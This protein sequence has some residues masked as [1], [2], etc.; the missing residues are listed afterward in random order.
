MDQQWCL[1]EKTI[2]FL[3][4]NPLFLFLL[5]VKLRT[6]PLDIGPEQ[7]VH[8]LEEMLNAEDERLFFLHGLTDCESSRCA[9]RFQKL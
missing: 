8:L 7:A 5:Y 9:F 4:L 1:T 3:F 6:S 2:F